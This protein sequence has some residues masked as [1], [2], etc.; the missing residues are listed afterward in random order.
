MY[1]CACMRVCICS[2]VPLRV[3]VCVCMCVC[4]CVCV[5]ARACVCLYVWLR[6]LRERNY[7]TKPYNFSGSIG[8][9]IVAKM[10]M[11]KSEIRCHRERSSEIQEMSKRRHQRLRHRRLRDPEEIRATRPFRVAPPKDWHQ[12]P[13][14]NARECWSSRLHFE[15]KQEN[16]ARES[17]SPAR[18]PRSSTRT[19]FFLAVATTFAPQAPPLPPTPF[20]HVIYE[21]GIYIESTK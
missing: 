5:R 19:L 18:Y 17:Q 6:L 4:V 11:R 1:V 15:A 13:R 3:C 14:N 9:T 12:A 2:C 21:G 10:Q 16:R 20:A 8:P 7:A